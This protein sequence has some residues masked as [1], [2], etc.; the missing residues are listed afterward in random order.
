MDVSTAKAAL[1]VENITSHLSPGVQSISPQIRKGELMQYEDNPTQLQSQITQLILSSPEPE[2]IL[3]EIAAAVGEFFH[4]DS[5]L[6]AAK[7][8]HQAN[9]QISIWCAEEHNPH[10]VK[11]KEEFCGLLVEGELLAIADVTHTNLVIDS[12]IRSVLGIQTHWQSSVNGMIV[13]GRSQSYDW[14]D[15]EKQLI[16]LVSQWVATAINYV[17]LQ[18]QVRIVAQYQN[19]LNQ[20]TLAIHNC[21]NLD[22]IIQVAISGIAQVLQV[23]RGLMLLLK[24]ADPF[25][26]NKSLKNIPK[27]KVTVV[28]QC[29]NSNLLNY[30]FS[31]S[32]SHLCQQAFLDAPTPVVIP[33]RRNLEKINLE[34]ELEW[35]FPSEI[36]SLLIFPLT[37]ILPHSAGTHISKRKAD[38]NRND[39][40]QATVLGFIVLQHSQPRLWQAEELD[41]LNWVGRQVCSAIIQHQ[42]L[43]Q[44]QALVEERTAQL[45]SSLDVQAKLYKKTR[46]QIEQLRHLNKLKDDFLSTISHELR[47]PLTSMALAIRLLRQAELSPERRTK[48]LEILD[49][50]C[51]Q[52]INL[53]NDLLTLQKLE[54]DDNQIQLQ[55]IDIKELISHLVNSFEQEW[56]DKGLR[57]ALDLPERSLII[58]TEPE[59]LNRILVELLT[60]AGKYSQPDSTVYLRLA[61]QAKQPD[62]QLILTI[63]NTGSGISPSDINFIFDKFRRG[64]GVT[65]KAIQG[66]GL[67]L[68]L[69]K[70][71]VQHLNG[72]IDVKSSPLPNSQVYQTDFTLTLP[73]L[74]DNTK[75]EVR[76]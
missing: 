48:Y 38:S 15:R 42:T 40:L 34:S 26:K 63:S 75:V 51:N 27:A 22:Q 62:E 17:Q 69:V 44:V 7:A 41:L 32:E 72:T 65:E 73:P 67:G 74:S 61:E 36:P 60:N 70:S 39:Y 29:S 50:Q 20:L 8:S 23:D 55:K 25:H 31:L 33:D 2:T 4:V 35:V 5:C 76:H 66:T 46:E 1:T 19:L 18:R 59:S 58:H 56:N 30:S 28:G 3:P 10:T 21:G 54:S 64:H 9:Q 16:T 45:Q 12:P 14:N 11:L 24:Y 71:L 13:L 49:Q 52:E 53:I 57:L 37:E 68:A 47:T 6:V 43:R